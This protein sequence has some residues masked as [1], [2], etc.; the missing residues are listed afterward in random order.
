MRCATENKLTVTN[1]QLNADTISGGYKSRSETSVE[2]CTVEPLITSF[3]G[4]ARRP[5]NNMTG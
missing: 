3:L 5:G 4:T 2:I 1:Y